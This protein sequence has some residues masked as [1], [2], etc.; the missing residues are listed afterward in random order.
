MFNSAH[1]AALADILSALSF[2]ISNS[3]RTGQLPLHRSW[4]KKTRTTENNG[5]LT[6]PKTKC[7]RLVV[8][9]LRFAAKEIHKCFGGWETEALALPEVGLS[10]LN[11]LGKIVDQIHTAHRE[12]AKV[13]NSPP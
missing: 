12:P 3:K 5:S 7:S 9:L 11:Q 4:T 2:T 1:S 13:G 8:F 6:A 10:E